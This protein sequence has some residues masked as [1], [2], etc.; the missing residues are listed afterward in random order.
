M[1]NICRKKGG[2]KLSEFI[3]LTRGF[4]SFN[5]IIYSHRFLKQCVRYLILFYDCHNKGTSS[6]YAGIIYTLF[7]CNV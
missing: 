5:W 4:Y 3:D 7:V 6:V 2:N 1:R